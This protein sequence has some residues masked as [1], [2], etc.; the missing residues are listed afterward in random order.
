MAKNY[1]DNLAEETVKGMTEK[2]RA[3][4]YPSFA[5]V[6]YRN[7]DSPSGKRVIVPDPDTAPMVT[8]IY[9]RFATG[10][11]SI[12]ALVRQINFE[13]MMLR[14]RRFTSSVTHQVLRKRLYMGDFDWDGVTY[15]G[16]HEPL[17]TVEVWQRVQQLLNARAEKKTRSVKHDFAY[18]GL[19]HCGHC[20]C[21]MVGEIKKGR[22][23][24]YHC[25]GNR[26]KCGEPYTRQG[27]LTDAFAAILREFVIPQPVLDWLGDAVLE[28]DRTEQEVREQT[29][30]QWRSRYV[31][32]Q[33][34]MEMMYDDK[35]D[36]RISQEIFDKKAAEGRTQQEELLRKIQEI[37]SAT[38]APIDHAVDMLG[39][40][41]RASEL[42]LEQP[43]R[44][45]RHL[46]SVVVKVATWKNCALRTT[47]FEPFEILRHSNRESCRKENENPGSGRDLE[48]WLLR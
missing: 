25:T 29:V 46:I 10:E 3:G 26:G 36:G 35:L 45:Q 42:F 13:G 47:L 4:I 34:R 17:V 6:G 43:A 11:Y 12:R 30:K 37:Q 19:V 14:G 48:V 40:T 9:D 16:S 38:P 21:L 28:S 2:A 7:A 22:Y 5:P 1:L 20:G 44:E 39:L 31:Q 18:K 41:S 24:Y 33:S 15:K 23:V 27:V 32:I 8:Q